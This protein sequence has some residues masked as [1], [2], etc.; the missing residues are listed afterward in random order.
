M[1]RLGKKITL[2]LLTLL[3]LSCVE[4]KEIEYSVVKGV[5]DASNLGTN[6]IV[7]LEGDWIFVPSHFITPYEDFSKFKRYEHINV[8]WHTYEDGE[9]VRGYATYALKLKNLAPDEVYAIK[10]SDC[11]SAFKAY[12]NGEEVFHLGKVGKT[13]E[14]EVF[15]WDSSLI[16]LPTYGL[17]NAVLVFHISNFSDRYPG[18]SKPIKFGLYSTISAQKNKDTILFVIIAGYLLVVGAFFIS[19]Y[20]FYKKEKKALYFGLMCANFSLRVCCYDEFLITIIVPHIGSVLLFKLGYITFSLAIILVCLFVQE[21]FHMTK[22]SLLYLSFIP[23]IIY[24]LINIFASTYTSAI[25]LPFAQIYV[26][27]LGVYNITLVVIS[28]M[29]KNKDAKLFLLGL[30]LFLVMAIRDVLVAN[31]IIEGQFFAHVGVLVLLIPMSIIVLR[32][33]RLSYNRIMNITEDI[34]ETNNALAKF[35]PNEFMNFLNKKHVDVKLGDHI[36]KEMYIAF[37][38]IGLYKSLDYKEER[39]HTLEIYNNALQDINPIIEAYNGFIDKYLPE[40]LMLLFDT[41]AEN[42][43]KCM[44]KMEELVEKENV[45]R[46]LR[47]EEKI[48][49]AC[50]VH[51]GRLMIGTIGEEERMD[52]TVI[53]DVVNVASRL[54]FYALKQKVSIF[55]SDVVKNNFQQKD[56][57]KHIVFHYKGKVQFRGKDETIDIYEVDKE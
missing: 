27:I 40:G 21:L 10:T 17:K 48:T 5:Y 41:T 53:S 14:E 12:L 28:M 46:I 29:K 37:V 32:S 35:L 3:F 20:L 26:L 43:I 18:F 52:S 47:G 22:R 39:Y 38:H 54:H 49:F 8:G 2:V 24:L 4:K 9:D 42:V 19:L 45:A 55:V 57:E 7:T 23:G 1:C 44:L 56:N 31:R 15:Q 51:Y 6:E 34:D 50:G 25:Y 13:K 30:S 36:L 16:V 33:F 11:S